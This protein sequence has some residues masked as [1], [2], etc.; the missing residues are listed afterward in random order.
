MA[1]D[2]A[3]IWDYKNNTT[4]GYLHLNGVK[5]TLNHNDKTAV[6]EKQSYSLNGDVEIPAN[7][8]CNNVAFSVKP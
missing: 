6:I 2:Y 1:E 8:E 5:Y 3:V 4:P 7:V